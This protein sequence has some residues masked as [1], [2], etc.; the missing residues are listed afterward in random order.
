MVLKPKQNSTKKTEVLK[1]TEK[2]WTFLLL[3]YQRNVCKKE[4]HSWD[5]TVG[6]IDSDCRVAFETENGLS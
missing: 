6:V 5:H 4:T 2:K 1:N 3:K